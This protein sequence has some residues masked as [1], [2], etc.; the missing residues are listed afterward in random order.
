MAAP[1]GNK[2][3]EGEGGPTKYKPEYDKQA[4]KLCLLGATDKTLADFFEVKEQTINNWKKNYPSFFESL[5]EGKEFADANVAEKLY[6][7][8]LG[9]EHDD[10]HITNYQG[11]ITLTPIKKHYPPD[12]TSGIFWLKNRQPDKWRDKQEFDH[13]SKGDKI[14]S[15]TG[16]TTD[17]LIKRAEALD[18]INDSKNE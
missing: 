10:V 14:N 5:K 12:A 13:T 6:Q 11:E 9:Y 3:A 8:A 7:R 2:F 16:L 15:L 4:Y 18:K 17:E 1:I